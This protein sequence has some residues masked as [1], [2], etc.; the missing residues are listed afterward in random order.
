MSI[1]NKFGFDSDVA[2]GAYH[3]LNDRLIRFRMLPSLAF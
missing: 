2:T 1:F 3:Y